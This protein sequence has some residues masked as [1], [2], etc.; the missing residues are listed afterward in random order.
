[1]SKQL[2]FCMVKLQYLS[3]IAA[4]PTLD[5]IAVRVILY[6]SLHH[7]DH[8]TG[9]AR[10]TFR[11]IGLAIGKHEKSVRRAVNKAVTAGYLDIER[12]TNIGNASRY[13]P[14][15]KAFNRARERRKEADKIVPLSSHKGGQKLL[16]RGTN[17]S[18]KAG[19][20]CPPNLD[21]E[22]KK[23]QGPDQ[24]A[25]VPAGSEAA[26]TWEKLFD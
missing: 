14:T 20:D 15:Q 24:W 23:E 12:G 13:R 21:R 17:P 26:R 2:P 18:S 4:A 5:D 11:T 25:V 6:L 16:Q 7:A 22:H 3:E 19:R 8:V 10:P 1:M 9:E